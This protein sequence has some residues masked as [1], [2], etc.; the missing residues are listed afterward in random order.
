MTPRRIGVIGGVGPAA[1]ILYY[2]LLILGGAPEVVIDSLDRTE[3]EDY[4][5]RHD[6][7]AL[8]VR[9]DRSVA[10]L[11]KVGCDGVVIACNSMH[12]VYDRVAAKATIPVVDLIGAVLD[13]IVRRRY[14]SVGLIGTTFVMRSG[15]YRDPLEASDIRCLVPPDSEQDWI[16][17]AILDDLQREVV[18]ADTVDR[19]LRDVADLRDRGARAIILGCTDLPV[20]INA[21]NS[22]IPVLDT[23]RIHVDR[24]LDGQPPG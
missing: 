8:A 15:I 21:G 24:V 12:V 16:M 19:L 14:R 7:D 13:E 20:A 11:A 6:V 10:D 4:L 18:P 5:G 23:A 22:P 3:I 1:T 2:R 9:L 17:G